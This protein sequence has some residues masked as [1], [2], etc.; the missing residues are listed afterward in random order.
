M[1]QKNFIQIGTDGNYHSIL[2]DEGDETQYKDATS[3]LNSLVSALAESRIPYPIVVINQLESDSNFLGITEAKF[4]EDLKQ[5]VMAARF[6][7]SMD[8]YTM[9]NQTP[10]RIENNAGTRM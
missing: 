10:I 4:N 8:Y 5:T 6:P 1:L 3:L 7:I 2:F 9:G